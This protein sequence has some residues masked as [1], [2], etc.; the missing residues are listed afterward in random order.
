MG[1]FARDIWTGT[2]QNFSGIRISDEQKMATEKK[3]PKNIL[4]Q[5]EHLLW[6]DYL[7]K[8]S[9]P[10][11]HLVSHEKFSFKV[12]NFLSLA[13]TNTFSLMSGHSK[14]KH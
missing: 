1:P 12:M 11:K 5:A 13:S 10:M 9:R 4:C 7:N 14:V 2:D 3:P 6:N 8:M